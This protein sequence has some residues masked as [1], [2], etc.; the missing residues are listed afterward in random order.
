MDLLSPDLFGWFEDRW[1]RIIPVVSLIVAVISFLFANFSRIRAGFRRAFLTTMSWLGFTRAQ[2]NKAFL[3]KHG[4]LR[5]IYLDRQEELDVRSA[6][7]PLRMINATEGHSE[8]VAIEVLLDNAQERIVILGVPGSGK[9]TLL[10]SFGIGLVAPDSQSKAEG[11]QLK[12]SGH[13]LPIYV[14]LRDFAARMDNHATLTEYIVNHTLPG[15]G[16]KDG[17]AFFERFLTQR[18]CVVLLDALDEVGAD[19]HEKVRVA[20]YNFI[21]GKEDGLPTQNARLVM[22]SRIHTFL[23]ISDAWIPAIFDGYHELAPFSDEDIQ[24][25]LSNRADDLPEGKTSRGLWEEIRQSGTLGLH[26]VPLILTISLGLYI[27]IPRY[28]IPGSIATFYEEMVQ[29]LLRRHD[30]RTRPHL[31]KRNTYP[32]KQKYL[33]LREFALHAAS[34]PGAFDEFSYVEL[35]DCFDNFYEAVAG[36]SRDDRDGFLNEIIEGAGLIRRI[37]EDEIY[38]FAHRSFHEYF[39]AV[40]LS[41]SPEQAT[42]QLIKRATDPL[43]RQVILFFAAAD[44]NQHDELLQGVAEHNSELAGNCVAV[45]TRVSSHVALSIVEKLDSTVDQSNA[46]SALR[47]L[48]AIARYSDGPVRDGA[49]RAIQRVLTEVFVPESAMALWSLAPDDLLHLAVDLALTGSRRV[50]NTCV[51]LSTLVEDDARFVAPLWSCLAT[52]V[53]KDENC[54]EAQRLVIRLLELAQTPAGLDIL[55]GERQLAPT[56]VTQELCNFVFPFLGALPEKTNLVTLLAWADRLDAVPERRNGFL[57]AFTFRRVL[58]QA[59]RELPQEISK[60]SLT[61]SPYKLGL[62]LFLGGLALLAVEIV[63][64]GI[65]LGWADVAERFISLWGSWWATGAVVIALGMVLG[66]LIGLVQG[67][68]HSTPFALNVNE[69]SGNPLIILFDDLT[70]GLTGVGTYFWDEDTFRFLCLCVV[71]QAPFIVAG[72]VIVPSDKTYVALLAGSLLTIICFWLPATR[73]F[74]RG[75][76]FDLRPRGPLAKMMNDESSQR[77]IR[78]YA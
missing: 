2:Y 53:G 76:R 61:V 47:A 18:Q 26:R 9:T 32:W 25:F 44:H 75:L 3:Q 15:Y 67:P 49:L 16:I 28:T 70:M 29:E 77:W 35:K 64:G 14:E 42:Q 51:T 58:D 71:A 10:K 36:L 21:E 46:V 17:K 40:E 48:S 41:K 31:R 37:S 7:V 43:W 68:L 72:A 66:V 13:W 39:A 78:A 34:R 12:Q 56:L 73:L 5:N 23:D 33:F 24:Q 69:I 22:T 62:I 57:E 19:D 63:W 30:F 54:A 8:R 4:Q 6:Y 60:S 65:T 38:V 27:T 50:A 52:F 55:L 20:V 74:G 11:V 59:W 45:A 1:V